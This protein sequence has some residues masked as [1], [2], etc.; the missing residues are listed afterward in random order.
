MTTGFLEAWE[1]EYAGHPDHIIRGSYTACGYCWHGIVVHAHLDRNHPCEVKGCDCASSVPCWETQT[2][3][4]LCWKP[5][6]LALITDITSRVLTC[7]GCSRRILAITGKQRT[8]VRKL[9]ETDGKKRI[10]H[11]EQLARMGK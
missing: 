2:K 5:A 1:H 6:R 3:C 9:H 8:V 4:D 7:I 11:Y 10:A